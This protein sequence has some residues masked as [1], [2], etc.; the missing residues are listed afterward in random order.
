MEAKSFCMNDPIP[1]TALQI[2]LISARFGYQE[3]IKT[4]FLCGV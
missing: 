2:G 3:I 1:Y 4:F